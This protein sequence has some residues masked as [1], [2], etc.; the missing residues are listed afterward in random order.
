MEIE[1]VNKVLQCRIY[2]TKEQKITVWK[3]FG[4]CRKTWNELLSERIESNQLLGGVLFDNTSPKHLKKKFPYLKEVDS[5]ALANVQMDLNRACL[6]QFPKGKTPNFKS[7]AKDK[8]SYT[9]NVVNN[10][11][12]FIHVSDTQNYIRLPK[13]GDVKIIIHCNI[14]GKWVLRHVTLKETASGKFYISLVFETYQKK[15]QTIDKVDP[16]KVEALDFSMKNLMVSMSGLFDITQD[17]I[18]WY[19]KLEDKIAHA[20]HVL[21][22]VEYGSN[23]YWKQCHKLGKLHEKAA[24]RRKDFMHKLSKKMA[25][26]FDVVCVED[27]DMQNMSRCLNFGKSTLDN[28]FGMFRRLLLYKLHAQGKILVKANKWFASSQLCSTCG[29]K[30][31]ETKDLNVRAW[32]CPQCGAVH[33]RDK[34]ACKNLKNY[35]IDLANRWADGDRLSVGL[36]PESVLHELTSK[37]VAQ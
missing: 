22:R 10:N 25:E 36:T 33:D 32:V 37:E 3:T 1:K 6:R 31:P 16:D 15:P 26:M 20:Q 30:N 29:Y 35:A 17:E 34:N 8:R 21:S 5:L 12:R 23:N 19:R 9:T 11:I 27:L 2:P 14:P 7:K 28:G 18:Q 13:L 4:C 24:N